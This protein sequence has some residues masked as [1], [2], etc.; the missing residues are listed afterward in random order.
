MIE[1]LMEKK[2]ITIGMLLLLCGSLGL[3]LL[4]GAI[5]NELI[6]ESDNMTATNNKFLLQCKNKFLTLREMSSRMPNVPIFVEKFLHQLSFGPLSVRG[7]YYLSGQMMI[8][9]V[10]LSGIGICTLL[11]DGVSLAKTLPFYVFSFI[12]LYLYFSVSSAV[13]RS[14]KVNILKINLIDYLENHLAAKES[15]GEDRISPE[16]KSTPEKK[17]IDVMNIKKEEGKEGEPSKIS[18]DATWEEIETLLKDILIG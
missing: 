12:G 6:R 8:L 15:E 5:L 1:V 10:L 3:K 17:S 7:I 2:G 13:D 16:Q 9:S 14:T 18:E 11:M 4:V